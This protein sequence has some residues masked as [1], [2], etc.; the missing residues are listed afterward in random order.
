MS[1][2]VVNLL[3]SSN[4]METG[5]AVVCQVFRHLLSGDEKNIDMAG[6]RRGNREEFRGQHF[7]W[8]WISC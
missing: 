7:D 1:L 4:S 8:G 6:E 3:R 5:I 2:S